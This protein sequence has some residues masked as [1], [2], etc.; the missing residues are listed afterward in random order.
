[1]FEQVFLTHGF[2]KT[3]RCDKYSSF[4]SGM[5]KSLQ[6]TLYIHVRFAQV[7]HH[8]GIGLA[9]RAI[10]SLSKMMKSFIEDNEKDWDKLLKYFCF[11]I[12]DTVNA[13]T[14]FSPSYL[15]YGR[16]WRGLLDVMRGAWTKDDLN[17]PDTHTPVYL[18]IEQLKERLLTAHTAAREYA[19]IEQER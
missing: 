12:N 18:Y 16:K 10:Q 2:P 13:T 11:A 5:M 7:G 8:E 4:T 9:E 14:H 15:V 6:E 1:M 17:I 3:L 19:A